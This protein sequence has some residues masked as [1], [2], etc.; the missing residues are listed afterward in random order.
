MTVDEYYRWFHDLGFY[1]TSEGTALVLEFTNA[2][3]TS[4]MVTRPEEL[5]PSD[6]ATAIDRYKHY[7]STD[8][9]IGGGGVH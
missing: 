3:G 9:P 4:L 6:R 7:L 5:T 2:H 1:V 8:R